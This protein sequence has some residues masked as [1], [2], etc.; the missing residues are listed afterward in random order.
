LVLDRAHSGVVVSTSSRFYTVITSSGSTHSIVV[1][2]PQFEAA[3][4]TY[5]VDVKALPVKVKQQGYVLFL[6]SIQ[7][8]Y[9][10]NCGDRSGSRNKFVELALQRTLALAVELSDP[11]TIEQALS[12]GLDI[13][14]VGANDFYSQRASVHHYALS[15]TRPSLTL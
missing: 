14:I 9:N 13:A 10:L 15:N 6:I 1:R 7:R 2:S 12:S 8:G 5:H 3:E 4:W 11:K